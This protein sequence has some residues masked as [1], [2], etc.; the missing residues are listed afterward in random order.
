MLRG[1]DVVEDGFVLALLVDLSIRDGVT[2][3]E[4]SVRGARRLAY[5]SGC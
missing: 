4:L 2:G 3:L 1:G 5:M